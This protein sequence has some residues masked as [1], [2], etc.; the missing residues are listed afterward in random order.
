MLALF[1]LSLAQRVDPPSSTTRGEGKNQP[2]GGAPSYF[3]RP[4]S[5]TSQGSFEA[6]KICICGLKT[7]GSSSEPVVKP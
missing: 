1:L 7:V 6:V 4:S 2:G 5:S 3:G